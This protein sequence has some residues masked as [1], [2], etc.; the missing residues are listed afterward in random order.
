MYYI[1]QK[2]KCKE[3]ISKLLWAWMIVDIILLN[4]SLVFFFKSVSDKFLPMN[5]SDLLN[6]PCVLFDYFDYHDIWHLLSALGLFIFMNIVFFLDKNLSN[7]VME[8]LPIF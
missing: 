1:F 2:I 4:L 7:N 6:E 8:E 3:K 5:E